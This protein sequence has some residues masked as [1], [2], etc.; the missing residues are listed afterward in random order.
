MGL[1][2]AQINAQRSSAAAADLEMIMRKENIDI[3]CLQEPYSYKG[4]VRGYTSSGY[5]IVQ[6]DGVNPWVAVIVLEA[7]LQIFRLACEKSEH[8]L[9]LHIISEADDFYLI[10]V[11]CQ[12][13]MPIEPFLTSVENVLNNINSNKVI[14]MMDSNARS[15]LWFS[16]KADERGKII[17]EF[18]LSKNLYVANKPNNPPTCLGTWAVKY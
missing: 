14:V 16:N 13:S 3:L 5:R 6:P 11:Y 17:E 10:N 2:I 4:K 18:L 15:H 9:C 12:F 7:K 8:L 1:R